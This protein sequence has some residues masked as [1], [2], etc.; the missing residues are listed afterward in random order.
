MGAVGQIVA[1]QANIRD[2]AS[3]R[4]AIEGADAVVN[5]V[6]VLVP[7][8]PQT[9]TALHTDGAG[10]IARI[11]REAGAT[12]LVHVSAIGA[13]AK[14]R[15]VYARTKAEAEA[16][17][18]AQFPDAIILRPS[19]VF[20]AEDQFFNRFASLARCTPALPLIGG[21]RTRFEPVYVGDVAAAIANALEG[22][23]RLG[24]IYE[25]GGPETLTFR[26]LMQRTLTYSGR[27]RWLVP[28]P[29]FLA[30]LQAVL[31][32]PLPVSLRPLTV[33]QVRLLQVD[34]IVSPQARN[35]GRTLAGLGVKSP[36]AFEAVVP[37]YL[38]R[39]KPQGQFAH[40]R[41]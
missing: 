15:S 5:L 3:V 20:G 38:E 11:A 13:D 19:I 26:E 10:R 12:A 21:G 34:N 7:S 30:K 2:D 39:F 37:G 22:R 17:V 27:R 31:T 4:R 28:L 18:F 36:I 6:S 9:Y 1:V 41:D 25:L 33:D 35:D 8:G 40:Y 29:V 14:S 16:A 24:T 23:G 32:K